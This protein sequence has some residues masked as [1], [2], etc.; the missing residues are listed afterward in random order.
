M[1]KRI[2][3]LVLLASVM[4][5]G[6]A[7]AQEA[8]CVTGYG[9]TACGYNCV[10]GYGEVKCSQTPMGNCIQGYGSVYCWDPPVWTNQQAECISG[11][12]DLAC[13]YNCVSGYGEV[14]CSQTPMGNCIQGYG[15]VYCWD[16]SGWA[17][18]Q[19]ECISGYGDLAC[20]YSCVSAYGEV[21]CSSNPN[22]VCQ[23][24]NGEIVCF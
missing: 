23:A 2:A 24:A 9:Q 15:S 10:S 7:F 8:Q 17:N 6:E 20:G 4:F 1:M 22:G 13:G 16:P 14:K 3:S 12:G 5:C 19:A 11:Y 21:K 18:R